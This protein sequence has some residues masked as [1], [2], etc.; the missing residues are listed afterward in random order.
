[1]QFARFKLSKSMN[2]LAGTLVFYA[3]FGMLLL[4]YIKDNSVEVRW[5]PTIFVVIIAIAAGLVCK[6]LRLT[7]TSSSISMTLTPL[8]G[9]VGWHLDWRD[10]SEIVLIYAPFG[11]HKL[12][13]KNNQ[14]YRQLLLSMWRLESNNIDMAEGSGPLT[15]FSHNKQPQDY[16]LY[17]AIELF[18]AGIR[19][20]SSR[21]ATEEINRHIQL[22]RE[23]GRASIGAVCLALLAVLARI[24]DQSTVIEKGL[25]LYTSGI[26]AGAGTI[27]TLYYLRN[28]SKLMAK[29]L[30]C[31][32]I[33]ACSFWA[34]TA[35]V[36]LHTFLFGQKEIKE[37]VLQEQNK[38]NQVWRSADNESIKITIY[39]NNSERAFTELNS[40][41]NTEIA[42]GPLGSIN[43]RRSE[44]LRF[45]EKTKCP[46][47]HCEDTNIIREHLNN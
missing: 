27:G 17:H 24:V 12:L 11:A 25:T 38:K 8:K 28:E 45:I 39:A 31:V 10:I 43:V 21:E 34:T 47:S 32:L 14:R 41:H 5:L 30:I 44:V 2:L 35:V 40:T 20:A 6:H 15:V 33:C 9:T 7:L 23:A 18:S 3:A 4:P 37:F 42:R 26:A 29:L 19:E 13:I 36:N 16:A 22:S 1:M 46:S